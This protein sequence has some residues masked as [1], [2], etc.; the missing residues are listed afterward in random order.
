MSDP[1]PFSGSGEF[2]TAP[3]AIRGRRPFA[4]L[5]RAE[6]LCPGL[7]DVDTDVAPAQR[8]VPEF[9]VAAVKKA[10]DARL[11][12]LVAS[13]AE[14][15]AS[16][17]FDSATFNPPLG[18]EDGAVVPGAS[19][20]VGFRRD[21]TGKIVPILAPIAELDFDDIA[22]GIIEPSAIQPP[23]TTE[24]EPVVTGDPVVIGLTLGTNGLI[25]PIYAPMGGGVG[26]SGTGEPGT[27]EC[28]CSF[29]LARQFDAATV[30]DGDW[31]VTNIGWS[32]G[33]LTVYFNKLDTGSSGSGEGSGSEA[34]PP[35]THDDPP[36]GGGGS[37]SSGGG[38]N[39]PFPGQA[40]GGSGRSFPGKIGPCW[41]K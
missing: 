25:T 3:L 2:P 31:V 13:L 4:G 41:G 24:P 15:L 7:A 37:G 20:V 33:I 28:T 10:Q 1:V 12:V 17:V 8:T 32:N 5:P 26:G 39:H 35:C 38:G 40:G 34:P 22:S 11:E 29:T 14:T 6:D 30:G 27:G 23:P 16:G 21:E 18:L 36:G 9:S 19:V